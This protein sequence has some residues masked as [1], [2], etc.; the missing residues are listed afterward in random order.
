MQKVARQAEGPERIAIFLRV[1]KQERTRRA[2]DAAQR[3]VGS[4]TCSG[5]SKAGARTCSGVEAA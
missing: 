1:S 5:G 4:A 2:C 3:R